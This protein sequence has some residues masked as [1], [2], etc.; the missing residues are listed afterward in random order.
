MLIQLGNVI[1]F[2]V[3]QC[4]YSNWFWIAKYIVMYELYNLG[5]A[6]SISV[7]P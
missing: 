5:P 2:M 7:L 6:N 4:T 3:V 1:K